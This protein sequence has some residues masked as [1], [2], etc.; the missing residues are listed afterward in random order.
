MTTI[1]ARSTLH[2]LN[3]K[4][5]AA[6]AEPGRIA[7]GG[8]L[9]LVVRQR[10]EAIEKLWVFR[11]RRGGR[12][13]AREFT[14]SLG[15]VRDVSLA[16]AR[17]LAATARTALAAGQDPRQALG[18][19]RG[20]SRFGAIADAYVE[21]VGQGLRSKTSLTQWKLTL[22]DAYCRCLRRLP[23]DQIGVADVLAVLQPIWL[24]KPKTARRL[25]ERLER[26]LD[27]AA[28]KGLRTGDNP[29]RWRGNLAHL[30][31]KQDPL[32]RGHHK[33]VPWR[34]MPAFMAQLREF[35]S[36]SALALE[37]TILTV[38][39]TGET[40]GA[41]W[42]EIDTERRIWVVPAV[43]MKSGREHRVAL[44]DRAMQ[45]LER[46]RALGGDYVFPGRRLDDPLS[47]MA[48]A[49]CLRGIRTD[50]TVHGMR[51]S[52]R[53]WCGEATSFAEKVAEA[54]LAHAAG[55]KT[56][57]AYRRG[58]AL[59]RRRELMSAWENYLREATEVV[60]PL[61]RAT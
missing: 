8:G 9:Y 53:D 43:R 21:T 10:G 33:A 24:E 38:A 58:D 49:M 59:E 7:D 6:V 56:E 50:A 57:Q 27:A 1:R 51:S 14:M 25:R 29:A 4:A 12:E 13:G 54:A 46:M 30:L 19:A 3:A 52:F 48:M 44:C 40:I 37:F 60:V 47:Q 42:S 31:P 15:P 28:V 23:V 20:T 17:E 26:V 2:K 32:K 45:I 11:Y 41:V 16:Q 35:N 55:D 36:V 22:G 5:V 34:E 18:R 39:R 61:R